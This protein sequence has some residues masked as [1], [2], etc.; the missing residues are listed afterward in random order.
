MVTRRA[1]VLSRGRFRNCVD[2]DLFRILIAWKATWLG[3]LLGWIPITRGDLWAIVHCVCVGAGNPK[4]FRLLYD[5]VPGHILA[6]VLC[7]VAMMV[8]Y[9]VFLFFACAT[10]YV[11]HRRCVFLFFLSAWPSLPIDFG[12]AARCLVCLLL[13]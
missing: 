10:V 8:L 13:L 5:P 2:F 4:G 1:S 7:L 9:R 12:E 11:V 6:V 3:L